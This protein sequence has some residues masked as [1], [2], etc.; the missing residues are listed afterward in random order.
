[1]MVMALKDVIGCGIIVAYAADIL[2]VAGLTNPTITASYAVGGTKLI[3]LFGRKPLLVVSGI[4][5]MIGTF[6]L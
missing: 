5:M 3:A 6:L 4:G 1:M 2:K